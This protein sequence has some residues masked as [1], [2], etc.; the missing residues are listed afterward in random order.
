MYADLKIAPKFS[1]YISQ[2]GETGGQSN[3]DGTFKPG[4]FMVTNVKFIANITKNLN[5]D[6]GVDNLFDKAYEY[7]EG[8][9]D[10][11]R[12]FF[13]NIRYDF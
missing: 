11:G 6:V 9:F 4:G 1:L 5:V 2:E 10:D 7:T 12:T 13:A 3:S 8:F